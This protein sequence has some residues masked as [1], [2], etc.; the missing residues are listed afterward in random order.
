MT[1]QDNSNAINVSLVSGGKDSTVAAAVANDRVELDILAYL[2]TGTGLQENREY[3]HSLA[4]HLGL[5]VWTLRTKHE[6]GERV[7]EHGFPGPSRHSIMY[8]SLKERQLEK[9]AT[10][11]NGRGNS[12]N[13][14][15]Y[16]GV[17]SA[18]SERRMQNVSPESEHSRWTWHAPIHDWSEQDCREYVSAN[19]LPRSD[20]W[21]SLG[22]SGDCFCGCFGS[23]S[24][25]LD[26]RAADCGYHAE[27]LEELERETSVT[28]ETCRWA[29]GALSEPER[30]AARVEQ[31]DEQ[32]LLCSDCGLK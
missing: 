1:N 9:L 27:W 22:R 3:I 30:R 2:D 13:L 20:L 4:D 15:L 31:D 18:E 12:S 29:W 11:C 21:E 16:S 32:M 23:P 6:Y 5:Q 8:R 10:I 14:H 7:K 25:L 26:L 28:D 19:D 17:R 24:E